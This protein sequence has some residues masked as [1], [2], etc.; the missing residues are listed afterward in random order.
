MA[1]DSKTRLLRDAEKY[2]LQGKISQAIAEYLKVVKDDPGDVLILN[3]V[4]D[5]YL[6]QGRIADANKLFFEVAESYIRNNFLLKA[7]AVYK[8]I[9]ASD[10]SNLELNSTIASLYAR[11]GMNVDA[12][13]QYMHVAEMCSRQGKTSECLEAY[14]KVVELDPMNA[15]VQLKLAEIHLAAE[16]RSKAHFY[17]TGAARA[18]TKTGDLAGAMTSYQRALELEPGNAEVL[19]GLL[20]TALQGGEVGS[21]LEQLSLAV[22][23]MPEDV[24]LRE[25]LGRAFLAANDID[26]A[27]SHF[28]IA[29]AADETRVENFLVV[30][31]TLLE[32]GEADRAAQ[33]L[34]PILPILIGH[35]EPQ[36]IIEAYK[37]ILERYPLHL[38]SLSKL[39]D[40]YAAIND[41]GGYLLT[42]D[43]LARAYAQSETPEE[44]LSCLARILE[45][46]PGSAEHLKA[47]RELF[48]RLYPDTPYVPPV[49]VVEEAPHEVASFSAGAGASDGGEA[50]APNLIEIDLLLNYGMKEQALRRL[51]DLE[52]QDPRDKQVRARLI[53]VY[54]ESENFAE[55]AR[56]CLLSAALER[57]AGKEDA[58]EKLLTEARKLAPDMVGA[59]FDLASYAS[60]HG[61]SMGEPKPRKHAAAGSAAGIELDLSGDLSEIFFHD[62]A[63]SQAMDEM[64]VESIDSGPAAEEIAPP[65]ARSQPESLAE[66]LQEVDFYL[67][68]GFHEEAAA[69]LSEI[70]R[71]NPGHPELA[72]RYARLN[73]ERSESPA[74]AGEIAE[75]QSP[76]PETSPGFK[77]EPIPAGPSEPHEQEAPA[78]EEEFGVIPPGTSTEP[79]PEACHAALQPISAPGPADPPYASSP[80]VGLEEICQE[81]GIN[82][83]FVDLI[84]EVNSLTDQEIARED[85]ET[86]FS[87][88][89]A[90]REMNLVDDA[91]KEFQGAIKSL[92]PAKAP[93]EAIQCCGMLSTCYLDKGM[94]R[95]AI[96]WCQTGLRSPDISAHERMALQY[97]MAVA[98]ALEGE[99]RR[100]LECFGDI[101]SIDPS[102]RDVAQRIDDLKAGHVQHA[103]PDSP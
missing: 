29:L 44:A 52:K 100:A 59:Q 37:Q 91:I 58:A 17:L 90:Y 101:F 23:Q 73:D 38:L 92:D 66:Q 7:I 10:P 22:G 57:R 79:V 80:P 84:D 47:H 50:T 60:R 102:Y 56:Q 21:V 89:I 8:K 30:G 65:I 4:G 98:Y 83:M 34:E 85:F 103:P 2:V 99:S 77:F 28:E 32:A 31:R 25:L 11:Q 49:T 53:A 20:E 68:L 16:N 88:G 15:A 24:E 13:I 64:E 42:L 78:A 51:V 70:A 40:V 48:A 93:H 95:S 14:E 81:A 76:A 96:R 43:K 5:L 33:C 87:L 55:A 9:L 36:R 26:S 67:R 45:C 71:E 63:G 3:T 6:R 69:K 18:Q 61:I 86:H 82:D 39:A 27:L 74:A 72:S 62:E 94:P 35:R 12:R 1:G 41:Q 54:R 97:D 19:K 75:A 46:N